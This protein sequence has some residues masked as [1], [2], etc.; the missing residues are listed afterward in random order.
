MEPKIAP[1]YWSNCD[2]PETPFYVSWLIHLSLGLR[3]AKRD[4]YSTPDNRI[5][6]RKGSTSPLYVE[7]TESQPSQEGNDW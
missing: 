7:A 6:R 5:A 1:C 4:A 2:V 3:G